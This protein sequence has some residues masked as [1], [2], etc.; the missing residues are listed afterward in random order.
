M[1]TMTTFLPNA[2]Q[3]L[4]GEWTKEIEFDEMTGDEED[5][6]L[7][8]TRATN[9]GE[10]LAAKSIPRRITEILSRCTVRIGEDY[11]PNGKTR[12]DSP[13]YFEPQWRAA[14]CSDRLTA[15][16]R[17][18][19]L[20]LGPE[21]ILSVPCPACTVDIPRVI[22]DLSKLKVIDVPVDKAKLPH[23]MVTLP[24]SGE[25]VSWRILRGE[26]DEE[27]LNEIG[28]HHKSDFMSVVTH[29]HLVS[30]NGGEIPG[31]LDYVKKMKTLD[32]RFLMKQFDIN[33]GSVDTKLEVRCP[34]CSHDF[35]FKL[36]PMGN[37]FFFPEELPG[38]TAAPS[39]SKSPP[40]QTRGDGH[41]E[42]SSL[43]PHLAVASTSAG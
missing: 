18:R 25:E 3:Q 12:D 30:V 39:T 7:D 22:F 13:G 38:A 31:G 1:T 23:H 42:R 40:S 28:K 27:Y 11:R 5:I 9:R 32:R 6:L 37:G 17:L 26:K 35:S 16:I 14:Y 36:N 43:S 10:G 33:Q 41:D 29:R 21:Y 15:L 24:K 4:N 2:I 34:E 8:M 20:S 19:Q